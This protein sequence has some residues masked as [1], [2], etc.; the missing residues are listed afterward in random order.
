MLKKPTLSFTTSVNAVCKGSEIVFSNTSA[1]L[2]NI[3]WDFKDGTTSN[4][5]SVTHT[6]QNSGIYNMSMSGSSKV[7]GCSDT[8]SKKITIAATPE[9]NI[10]PT[11]SLGCQVFNV[12]FENSTSNA[13]FF[14]WN[15]GDGNSSALSNP[16]HEY[17]KDGVYYGNFLALNRFGCVDSGKPY[18]DGGLIRFPWPPFHTSTSSRFARTLSM[19]ARRT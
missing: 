3:S 19:T 7:T 13:D 6:Y 15:F 17:T 2:S 11:D 16:I 10:S 5:S 1:N 8:I 14:T 12:Q 9:I 18:L 4:K